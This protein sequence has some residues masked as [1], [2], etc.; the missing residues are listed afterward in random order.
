ASGFHPNSLGTVTVQDLGVPGSI[1]LPAKTTAKGGLAQGVGTFF[2]PDACTANPGLTGVEVTL[3]DGEG[4]HAS[5]I[6]SLDCPKPDVSIATLRAARRSG[7]QVWPDLPFSGL[8]K[9]ATITPNITQLT[10]V[11]FVNA[12]LVR[13]DDGFTLVDTTLR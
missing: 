13:E 11:H 8:V 3:V 9:T 1:T 6:I 5:T 10:R 2:E 4:V 12:F 7:S